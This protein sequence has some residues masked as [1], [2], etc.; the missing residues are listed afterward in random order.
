MTGVV[1]A[2]A[3]LAIVAGCFFVA[4]RRRRK[5]CHQAQQ[6]VEALA[7][8]DDS[9]GSSS[10][11]SSQG[12]IIS[13]APPPE[14]RQSKKKNNNNN[15][16]DLVVNSK[17]VA[18]ALL[19]IGETIPG[20][21][22]VCAAAKAILDGVARLHRKAS[23]VRTAGERVAKTLEVLEILADNTDKV[24]D[25]DNNNAKELVERRMTELH[26]L[27]KAMKEQIDS[28]EDRGWLRRRWGFL[29]HGSKLTDLDAAIVRCLDN[30]RFAYQLM[31]DRH[32]ASLLEVH[33]YELEEAMVAE[34]RRVAREQSLS[35]ESAAIALAEDD[36]ANA[37]VAK[38]AHVASDELAA[39]LREH[40]SLVA[41]GMNDLHSEMAHVRK[42]LEK[43]SRRERAREH[44]MSV[45]EKHELSLDSIDPSP[46]ASGSVGLLHRGTYK[47]KTVAVKLIPLTGLSL[48]RR[49]KLLGE[50]T[51]ELTIMLSLRSPL[52]VQVFG[53][54]RRPRR[55]VLCRIRHQQVT[56][57]SNMLGLVMEY[58][59]RGSL[60]DLLDDAST[61][62][63]DDQRR[64]WAEEIAQGMVYI[65]DHGTE[66]RDL[67][68][69]NIL[70][71]DD[72]SCKISDFGLSRSAE[73]RTHT[74][75]E[76]K[77]GA[78]GT[79]PFM[80]PELLEMQAFTEKSDVYSYSM[81]LYEI[82]TRA[83][84]WGGSTVVQIVRSVVDKELRPV[85]VVS[86]D[87]ADPLL[88]TIMRH[89]WAQNPNERPSFDEVV[90]LYF[91]Q[92]SPHP[93][94]RPAYAASDVF[95]PS[96][97]SGLLDDGSTSAVE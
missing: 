96:R 1:A 77:R 39:E 33:K 74:T 21:A 79:A 48:A 40:L 88:V 28:F 72:F 87:V 92:V 64:A 86:N 30:L 25:G 53:V 31:N 7:V 61:P 12:T 84:P 41:E 49:T 18:D 67:K 75:L 54:A 81:V 89:C 14:S 97:E 29:N 3:A 65:Y 38:S 47:R 51:N 93:G 59:R 58:L 82:T 4:R 11:S 85:V 23:D 69:S 17:I 60:R 24:R 52:V 13:G 70:L 90:A 56:T 62:I 43:K 73:F 35:E 91:Q 26:D 36:E 57:E 34:V 6:K 94:T 8:V 95:L 9:A 10:S 5:T 83:H 44:K 16:E 45:L 2:G 27:L 55:T 50:F 80:A 68:S 66:H 15:I 19:D 22:P 63:T 42:G 76:S 78:A 32:V 71:A 46:F 37:A 20:I